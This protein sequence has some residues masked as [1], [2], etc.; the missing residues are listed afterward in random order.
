M[1][2]RTVVK[3]LVSD[4]HTKN[5]THELHFEP[6]PSLVLRFQIDSINFLEFLS[7]AKPIMFKSTTLKAC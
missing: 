4:V 1:F 7:H 3:Y 5:G 6:K 2:I